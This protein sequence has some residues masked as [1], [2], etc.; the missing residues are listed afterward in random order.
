MGIP[1]L[2]FV[3]IPS[4]SFTGYHL[5]ESGSVFF[6]VPHQISAHIDNILLSFLFC[7]LNNPISL[8]FSL[9]IRIGSN[10]LIISVVLCRTQP[11]MS[12]SFL[13]WGAQAWTEH[14]SCGL[15]RAK[16]GE[17][18]DQPPPPAGAAA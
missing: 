13:P 1:I 2:Q 14:S 10:P 16:S 17:G 4:C 5:A 3:P 15:S 11:S 6:A 18:K 7:S 8:S 12:M 9:Y